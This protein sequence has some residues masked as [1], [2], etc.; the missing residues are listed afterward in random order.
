MLKKEIKQAQDSGKSF[1]IYDGILSQQTVKELTDD[2][3]KL[4][5]FEHFSGDRFI[6]S[7]L[8]Q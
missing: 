4:K 3:F 7:W 8:I 2:G 5:Q 1:I 6:K